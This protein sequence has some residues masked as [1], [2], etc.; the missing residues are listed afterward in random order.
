MARHHDDR[1]LGVR[2]QRRGDGTEE[3]IRKATA[4]ARADDDHVDLGGE[5]YED[6]RRVARL[7]RTGHV[8]GAALTGQRL[9]FLD[10][11]FGTGLEGLVVENGIPAVEGGGRVGGQR[12]GAQAMDARSGAR[13]A[14]SGPCDGGKALLRAIDTDQNDFGGTHHVLLVVAVTYIVPH[15]DG[16]RKPKWRKIKQSPQPPRGCGDCL[17]FKRLSSARRSRHREPAKPSNCSRA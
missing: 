2:G 12:V 16:G 17:S 9:G 8:R 4:S 5:V 3:T 14:I 13:A 1:A 7:G 6:A 11:L 15:F 10:D